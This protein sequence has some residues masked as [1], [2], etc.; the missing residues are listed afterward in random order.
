MRAAETELET[1]PSPFTLYPGEICNEVE[2]LFMRMEMLALTK[3][4]CILGL[5]VQQQC[6]LVFKSKV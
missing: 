6:H 4:F 3:S 2:S 5:D 1:I